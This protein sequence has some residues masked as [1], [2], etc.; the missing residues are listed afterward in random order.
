[1]KRTIK[2][3]ICTGLILSMG[4]QA[5]FIKS[6][7]KEGGD[8]SVSFDTET[9]QAWLNLSATAG[10]TYDSVLNA[11]ANNPDFSGYRLASYSE[12][13]ALKD[14]F[15]LDSD[16]G[17]W[18]ATPEEVNGF[19]DVIHLTKDTDTFKAS[20]GYVIEGD[21]LMKVG[22]RNNNGSSY[23]DA[24]TNAGGLSGFNVMGKGLCPTCFGTYLVMDNYQLSNNGFNSEPGASQAVD[25]SEPEAFA[26][27]GLGLAGMAV[28]KRSLKAKKGAAK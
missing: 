4:A 18:Q 19:F 15:M 3:F 21:Q 22:A 13:L 26:L 24:L 12:T 23:F 16:N 17:Y 27:F 1:M 10:F 9:N 14:N 2:L 7:W 6:D 5:S 20:W 25:V 8:Q 11:L 28:R